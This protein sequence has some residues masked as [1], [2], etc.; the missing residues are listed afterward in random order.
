MSIESPV[1]LFGRAVAVSRA[2]LPVP[3]VPLA[4]PEMPAAGPGPNPTEP[5]ARVIPAV[6][7]APAP[8]RPAE[9]RRPEEA[10]G[11][12]RMTMHA[13]D[14]MLLVGVLAGSVLLGNFVAG[15]FPELVHDRMLP[16]ILGRSLG[17]GAYLSLTALVVLGLWLRHP[18]RR[19]VWS[20]RP[21]SMLRAHVA[22]A[23]CTVTLLV[24]HLTSIALDHYA[25][26]GWIGVFVPWHATYRPTSVALGTLATYAIVLVVGTVVLAGSIARHIWFP[27]HAVSAVIFGI[28]L[29]HA[30][31]AGSD[32]HTL[33]WMYVSTGVLVVAVQVTRLAAVHVSARPAVELE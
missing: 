2:P 28:T 29:L 31:F 21:E 13:K 12:E 20:P 9:V 11:L 18:W 7:V 23:A 6:P 1:D 5:A 27:V 10:P 33:R 19:R 3:E 26:V 25:G 16:W 17:V 4:V 32:S 15:S 22:L 24:G 30:L 14:T 8:V